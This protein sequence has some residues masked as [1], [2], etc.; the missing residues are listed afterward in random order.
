MAIKIGATVAANTS[1]F[2]NAPR[3]AGGGWV[4][5]TYAG[6]RGEYDVVTI[7]LP[8]GKTIK[9]EFGPGRVVATPDL[10]TLYASA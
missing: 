10:P 5:G 7:A 1:P 2:P 6:K 4:I 8:N 3:R 9:R